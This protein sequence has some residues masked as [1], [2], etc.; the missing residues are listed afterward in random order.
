MIVSG[1]VMAGE[2]RVFV[3][4]GCVSS[5]FTVAGWAAAGFETLGLAAAS[6]TVEG[7]CS[8]RYIVLTLMKPDNCQTCSCQNRCGESGGFDHAIPGRHDNQPIIR[9]NQYN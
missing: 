1:S 8:V 7:S 2:F 9:I 4:A 5:G 3:A 6:L